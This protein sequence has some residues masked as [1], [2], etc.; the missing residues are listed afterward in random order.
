MAGP[1]PQYSDPTSSPQTYTEPYPSQPFAAQPTP[2][3]QPYPP[4]QGPYQPA[5]ATVYPGMLPPPIRYPKR[6]RWWLLGALA[7]VIAV[8]AA[9]TVAIIYAARGGSPEAEGGALT[10]GSAK[11]AIQNYLD[12][13]SKGDY[14]T[15]ARNTLCGMYDAVKDRRSDQALARLSS[16]AFRKEFAKAEVTTIDKMVFWSPN[17]AQVLF[18]MRAVPAGRSSGAR[19]EEQAIAQ[20]LS[21]DNRVLVCSYLLRTAAQY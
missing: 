21:Q 18:T 9:T 10:P 20:L 8:V 15:V 16:D 2:P 19:D 7:L 14:E 6:R 4:S 3:G 1:Y 5:A 13:L 12:A 17:Q 11:V